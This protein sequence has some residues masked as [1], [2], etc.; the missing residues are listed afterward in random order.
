MN[1]STLLLGVTKWRSSN[2]ATL[3]LL[4]VYSAALFLQNTVVQHQAVALYMRTQEG[5]N[6]KE[7]EHGCRHCIRELSYKSIVRSGIIILHNN[8]IH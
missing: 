5:K 7:I 1:I 8:T 4:D 2:T 6:R 3:G